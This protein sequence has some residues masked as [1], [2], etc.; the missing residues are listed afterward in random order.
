MLDLPEYQGTNVKN[1]A[2]EVKDRI[3]QKSYPKNDF[4]L[5]EDLTYLTCALQERN[6]P[7]LVSAEEDMTNLFS[8]IEEL[9]KN[10]N[11]M[12]DLT[13]EEITYTVSIEMW[14]QSISVPHSKEEPL[15]GGDL[16]NLYADVSSPELS[17]RYLRLFRDRYYQNMLGSVEFESEVIN[18]TKSK[19]FEDEQEWNR[20]LL[21]CGMVFTV[22][23][24]YNGNMIPENRMKDPTTQSD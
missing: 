12:E 2:D 3:T 6:H 17:V 15:R 9:L 19:E 22:W 11:N 4:T 8:T 5:S 1:F 14:N 10:D 7:D 13:V 21:Y 23:N 16:Y 20:R 24:K 18:N